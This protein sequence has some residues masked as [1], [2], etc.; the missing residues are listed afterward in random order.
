ME[1]MDRWDIALLALAGYI[2]VRVLL[3]LMVGHRDQVVGR[4]RAEME[5][6]KQLKKNQPQQPP[7][8]GQRRAG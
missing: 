2:A 3:R 7:A 5:Q 1:N 4:F 6:E 8:P